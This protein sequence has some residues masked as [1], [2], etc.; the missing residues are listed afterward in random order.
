MTKIECAVLID[1][2][3][4]TNFLNEELIKELGVSEKVKVFEDGRGALNYINENCIKSN[5]C[6]ELILLD[7]NMPVMD[8]FEFLKVFNSLEFENK[9]DVKIIMLTTSSNS[10]DFE[11]AKKLSVK[12][13]ITKPLTPEKL[14]P[15]LQKHFY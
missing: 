2:D 14:M 1:D 12:D 13:Y 10:K 15:V 9:E 6:P 5:K 7:I 11:Q 8:G 3:S 4:I